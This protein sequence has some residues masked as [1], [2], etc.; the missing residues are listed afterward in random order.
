MEPSTGGSTGYTWDPDQYAR[1]AGERGRPIRELLARLPGAAGVRTVVDLGCGSGQL[2]RL[3]GE[4]YPDAAV[5]GVDSSA[6]FLTAASDLPPNVRLTAGDI[7]E[8]D[9]RGVD[10]L[11]SNAAFHWVPE[12]REL[13]RRWAGE[14]PRGGVLAF[15]VPGNFREP[16]HVLLREVADDPR[17][18]D[19]LADALPGPDAVDSAA[20]YARLLLACGLVPDA[21]ETTYAHVMPGADPVL[22]WIRGAALRPVLDLLDADAAADFEAG[23]GARLRAAYPA[24]PTGTVFPFRRVFVVARKP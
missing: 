23:Y 10:L 18:R 22:D 4:R 11:V 3:L 13:L 21:W 15:Q 14:L 20:G 12:H 19:A 16:S 6:D 7:V 17:W 1:Y 2:T 9:A 24:T 5:T 8:A